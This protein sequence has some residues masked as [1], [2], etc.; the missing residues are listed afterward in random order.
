MIWESILLMTIIDILIVIV[1]LYLFFLFK[2]HYQELENLGLTLATNF[3]L[4][5]LIV[6]AIFYVTDLTVMHLLPLFKSKQSV[7]AAM[8]DLHLNWSWMVTVIGIG[9]IGFGVAYLLHDLV[10]SANRTMNKLEK[11]IV[12]SEERFRNVF[13]KAAIGNVLVSNEHLILEVNE[14]FCNMLGYKPEELTGIKFKDI[15]C[16][17]DLAISIENHQRLFAGEINT[18]QIEKRYLHKDGHIIYALL[19]VSIV[20]D[21]DSKPLYAVAQIQDI[22]EK[23]QL[24]EKLVYHA[25]Y[26]S[27]RVR[28]SFSNAARNA[29]RFVNRFKFW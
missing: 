6:I 1:P 28:T 11:N 20:P 12:E 4:F 23:R 29:R 2:K 21:E 26:D 15:T 10:P 9:T 18:Y 22:T 7:M 14:A 25:R 17:D 8:T 16:P 24:S 3:I 5:G 19:N 13:Q 27:R